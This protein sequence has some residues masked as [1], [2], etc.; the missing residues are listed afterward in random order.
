M[1]DPV[2]IDKGN[3]Q[4]EAEIIAA[5]TVLAASLNRLAESLER[6][7]VEIL[8]PTSHQHLCLL[9]RQVYDCNLSCNSI[10]QYKTCKRISRYKNCATCI[11]KAVK[12]G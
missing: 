12:R 8:M 6:F 5:I 2:Y 9:C 1:V 7:A 10:S 4:Y 3:E 11:D